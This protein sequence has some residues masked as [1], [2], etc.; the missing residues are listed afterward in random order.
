MTTAQALPYAALESQLAQIEFWRSP[1]AEEYADYLKAQVGSYE[2]RS[3]PEI[4][5]GVG[6]AFL[7]ATPFFVSSEISQLLRDTMFDF[8]TTIQ[9]SSFWPEEKVG[10]AYMEQP[11][12]IP[13]DDESDSI[14]C[15]AILWVPDSD[16]LGVNCAFFGGSVGPERGDAMRLWTLQ[17]AVPT[18]TVGD[19]GPVPST[20]HF[21][22]FTTR[23][24]ATFFSF[25]R[26]KIVSLQDQRAA[27]PARK[28]F[29][30][31]TQTEAPLVRVIQLRRREVRGKE[32]GHGEPRD[33]SH[34][35][36]VSGHWRKQWYSS[37]HRHEPLFID[38]YVK[39]PD[40]KPLKAR[41]VNLYAVVN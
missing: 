21:T 38:S 36:I 35:W 33:W 2:I 12:T 3:A 29:W 10:F 13:A 39:G 27:R 24:T 11:F 19:T 9:W 30:R 26:Q 34:R 20:S 31:I 32:N 6:N 18:T 41:R 5:A 7:Q 14:E 16:R 25:L 37:R 15:R 17:R 28:R 8:P 4:V 22:T 23:F 1:R 40:D